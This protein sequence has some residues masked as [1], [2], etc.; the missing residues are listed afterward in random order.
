M[1]LYQYSNTTLYLLIST[2][3]P[4]TLSHQLLFWVN[5]RGPAEQLVSSTVCM[6]VKRATR[7]NKLLLCDVT[8]VNKRLQI[9]QV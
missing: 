4:V 5:V 7:E 1:K 8:N 2:V 9:Y 6:Y 3:L